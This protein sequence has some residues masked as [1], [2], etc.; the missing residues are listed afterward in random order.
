MPTLRTKSRLTRKAGKGTLSSRPRFQVGEATPHV[1]TALMVLIAAVSS[2]AESSPAEP[3]PVARAEEITI[4][5]TRD[6]RTALEVPAA[7]TVLDRD[8]LDAKQARFT[9]DLF[10]GVPGLFVQQTTPGQ[11]VPIVRG[12][13]G[14]SVLTL[15]DGMRLNNAIYRPCAEPVPRARRSLRR[16]SHRSRARHG[17]DAL[18]QRRDGWRRQCADRRRRGS[19]A[20]RGRR[21]AASWA[22]SAAPTSRGSGTRRSRPDGRAS[23]CAWAVRSSVSTTCAAAMDARSRPPTTRIRATENSSSR[24]AVKSSRSPRSTRVSPARLVMTSSSPDV[25]HGQTQP[26]SQTF[27][28]EPN[29]RLFTHAHYRREAPMRWIEYAE[30]DF[31][32][33]EINDDRRTSDF[34]STVERRERN[35]D[36][37]LSLRRRGGVLDRRLVDVDL[38]LRVDARSRREQRAGTPMA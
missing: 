38:R 28:F 13:I 10:R 8:Q 3:E 34:G 33:Q 7:V 20:T 12:L 16:R 36:R 27:Y 1:A 23:A 17:L 22:S 21:A 25:R 9:P 37:Q 15:V 18:R 24:A 32:F 6:E 26:P 5:A 14:S 19:R 29:D 30:A 35:R 2:R 4:T 31:A 11:G